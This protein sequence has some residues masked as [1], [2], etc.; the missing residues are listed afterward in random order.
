M[1]DMEI[2]FRRVGIVLALANIGGL[3]LAPR[4]LMAQPGA[5]NQEVKPQVV[6]S[7]LFPP[8]YPP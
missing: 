1:R 4:T 5:K 6:L 3:L 8:I 2:N 7:K